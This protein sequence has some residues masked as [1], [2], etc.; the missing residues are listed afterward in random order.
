MR[1]VYDQSINIIS[2]D[3]LIHN[4]SLRAEKSAIF[5]VM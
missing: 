5:Y 1:V 3:P 2:G 4:I